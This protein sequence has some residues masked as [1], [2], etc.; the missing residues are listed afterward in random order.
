MIQTSISRGL[1]SGRELSLQPV[2]KLDTGRDLDAGA[3]KGTAMS[4][5]WAIH[6]A[7]DDQDLCRSDVSTATHVCNEMLRLAQPA[8]LLEASGSIH[9]G[10]LQA[11]VDLCCCRV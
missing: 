11:L 4:L 2:C 8:P 9:P 10:L 1:V 7:I 3:I 6:A 5:H